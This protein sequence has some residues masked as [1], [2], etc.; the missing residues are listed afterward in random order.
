MLLAFVCLTEGGGASLEEEEGGREEYGSSAGEMEKRHVVWWQREKY[1]QKCVFL[2]PS[3]SSTSL[4]FNSYSPFF[5]K[6]G[7]SACSVD[8]GKGREGGP[9]IASR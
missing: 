5:I 6:V 1:N 7:R 3:G 9:G 4:Q 8:C 2:S